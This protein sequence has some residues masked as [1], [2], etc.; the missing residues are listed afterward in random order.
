MTNENSYKGNST[1]EMMDQH[2]G[3]SGIRWSKN[4]DMVWAEMQSTIKKTHRNIRR[5]YTAISIA[6]TVVILLGVLAFMRLHTESASTS[7]GEHSMAT[8]PD[9]ST[10]ELNAASEI[11]WHPHWWRFQREVSFEGE[12]FFKVIPGSSFTVSSSKGATTVLGTSFNIFSRGEYYNVTCITG[13]V[14][15]EASLTNQKVIINPGQ[16][17]VLEKSGTFS[18][19]TKNPVSQI[20]GWR[21]HMFTF[22]AMPLKDVLDEITRQYNVNIIHPDFNRSYTGFF[23]KSMDIETVLDLVCRPFEFTFDKT[24]ERTYVI[25]E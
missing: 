23:S 6:A 13:M 22:T 17:A 10:V 15:A 25:S 2:L 21:N 20:T 9:G 24:K 12:G 4:R 16:Q 7:F 1:Q 8:L 18:L 19:E 5:L 11:S 14:R 3:R